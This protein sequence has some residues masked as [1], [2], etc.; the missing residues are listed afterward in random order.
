MLMG[1]A[2]SMMQFKGLSTKYWA[3]AV[4]TAIYLGNRSPTST[5]DGKTPYEA[6]YGFK[7]KVNNLRVFGSTC[8]ALVPKEKRTKLE[9]Q[10]MKCIFIGYSDEKKG[11]RL[12]SDGKFIVSRD[13]IFYETESNNLYEINHLLSR[14]EKKNT[15]GKGKFN[16]SKQAFWFEKDF[17]TPEDIS[18]SKVLLIHMIMKRKD[19][20]DIESSK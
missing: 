10:S 7:P 4:H 5:L 3:E 6:W 8:Y 11:Y 15:K 19:F 14:L 12:L 13:V 18:L 16:K 2:R 1:M 20:Y 17:V 9:N